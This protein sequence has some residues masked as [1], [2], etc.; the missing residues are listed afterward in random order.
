MSAFGRMWQ[1]LYWIDLLS[2]LAMR[3]HRP[4]DRIDVVWFLLRL[5]CKPVVATEVLVLGGSVS[6]GGGVGNDPTRAWHSMLG[7]VQ[8]TVHY[9]SA[10]DPSYFLHCTSRFVQH[11][12]D[13]VLL[14]LGANMFDDTCEGSL[15]ALIKR[16]RCLHHV[17]SVAVVNWPGFIRT[18]ASRVAAWRARATLIEVPHGP[19]LYSTDRVHPNALGHALIAERVRTHL[20][21]PLNDWHAP[22]HC[23][24]IESEACYP[25]ATEMP[26][27]RDVTGEPHGWKLV[28]ESPTPHLVH[29][30]GWTSSTPGANLT[31]VIPQGD[32]CGA[33]V[34]LAYLA[35]EYTGPFRLSC[36]PGCACTKIRTFHQWR[37]FPF[38]VVTGQEEWLGVCNNC[39]RLKVTRSTAFN[40]LRE[41]EA[42]C[43]VTVTVLTPRRVRL[44]GLYV[45]EPSETYVKY[46][47]HSPPS[48][49]EQRW[50]GANALKTS[51]A[52][53]T[54]LHTV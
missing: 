52:C 27:V 40:Q 24:P 53:D 15:V 26:V 36:A 33:M 30:Y 12:Y 31:L 50:F 14:D 41:R 9:K 51:D 22:E 29:K 8:P 18:N 21:G 54:T 2:L 43:R 32:T 16:M 19:D 25:E 1:D 5:L 7:D 10:I 38:P 37:A 11:E 39:S 4:W 35:S 34:S 42:P 3:Q 44:D 6:A 23:A 20:A 49:A 17:S 28:D 46:T 48:T 47:R 45:Q 13:A